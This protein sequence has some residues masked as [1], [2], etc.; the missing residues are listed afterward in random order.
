MTTKSEYL[1]I[2]RTGINAVSHSSDS[3]AMSPFGEACYNDNSIP[4]L[5]DALKLRAADKT[6]C[7]TWEITPTQWRSGIVE[8]L[9]ERAFDFEES[10]GLT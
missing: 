3:T 1:A 2:I 8:A 4:E 5:L 9:E 6:D 10:N 7:R